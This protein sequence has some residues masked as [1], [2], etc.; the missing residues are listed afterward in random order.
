MPAR[1]HQ[2][3]RSP[4]NEKARFAL[5]L[6][7]IAHERITLLPGPHVAALLFRARTTKTPALELESGAFVVGSGAIARG[8]DAGAP[9]SLFP[10]DPALRR[11]AERLERRF[12]DDLTPRIRRVVLDALLASPDAWIETFAGD[13][14]DAGQTRYR[15]RLPFVAPAVRLVNGIRGSFA[16]DGA[17]AGDDARALIEER[18]ARTGHLVGDSLTIADVTAAATLTM[19]LSIDHPDTAYSP[20]AE[21]ALAPIAARAQRHPAA[22]WARDTY[23]RHRPR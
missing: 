22:A 11:D 4:Y 5:A 18:A 8:V 23:A 6:A 12:D 13:E 15:R 21:R 19:L 10:P 2:F 20:A 7:G 1:L 9:R 14:D 3:R 17:R 16:A